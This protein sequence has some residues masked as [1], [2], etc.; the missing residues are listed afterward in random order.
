MQQPFDLS[1]R[2]PINFSQY[3][4]REEGKN[5]D[6]QVPR[7]STASNNCLASTFADGSGPYWLA[8]IPHGIALTGTT[9]AVKRRMEM[10]SRAWQD[11]EDFESHSSI[12]LN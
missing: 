12:P 2:E 6:V 9:S 4:R 1:L 5:R 11:Y 8:L 10:M 7:K 3:Y